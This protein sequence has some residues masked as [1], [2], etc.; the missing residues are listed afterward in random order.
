VGKMNTLLLGIAGSGKSRECIRRAADA[1]AAGKDI[2]YLVPNRDE[3]AL[4][5]RRLVEESG[6]RAALLPGIE[7]LTGLA[8]RLFGREEPGRSLRSPL[9]R[10]L[11]IS[12]QLAAHSGSLGVLE[13]S[14]TTPGFAQVLDSLFTELVEG[15]LLPSD[16]AAL[17]AERP[18]LLAG[19]YDEFLESQTTSLDSPQAMLRVVQA[20]E[21]DKSK[22]LPVSLLVADGFSN[23]SPLQLRFIDALMSGAE[24]ALFSICMDPADLDVSPRAP[25]E[26]LHRLAQHYNRKDNWQVQTFE[27]G[28]RYEVDGLASLATG[29]FREEKVEAISGL[30][31][32]SAATPRDEAEGVAGELRRALAAGLEASRAAILYR[33]ASYG[34]LFAEALA[35]AGVPFAFERKE[36]LARRPAATVL[37]ALLD[38]ASGLPV[39]D[40]P[41]RL[42]GGFV[43]SNDALFAELQAVGHARGLRSGQDWDT[44]FEEFQGKISK[45]DWAWLN[46]K[47]SLANKVHSG[48]TWLA[49]VL[50]PLLDIMVASVSKNSSPA[51]W[52]SFAEDLR[53]LE[54]LATCARQ[55]AAE[56]LDDSSKLPL[57]AWQTILRRGLEDSEYRVKA[58]GEGGGVILGNPFEM[59]LP[60]L[61]TVFICGLNRGSFPPPF[62]DHP[63]LRES[64]RLDL[65]D[66]LRAKGRSARLSTWDDRQAEE[67]YLFYV[68]ATRA[69]RRLVMT[70]SLRDMQGRQRPRSF[71][72]DEL[73][74]LAKLPKPRFLP[75]LSLETRLALPSS[76]RDLLRDSLLARGRK[77]SGTLQSSAEATLRDHGF[78][79]LLDSA[80]A[81]ANP[82]KLE[83]HAAL[84]NH[85]KGSKRF[86]PTA[87]E[88]YAQCPFRY[89]LQRLLGLEEDEN[90]TPGYLEEGKLE[91]KILELFY[92]EWTETLEGHALTARLDELLPQAAELLAEKDNLGSLLSHRFRAED[93]RRLRRLRL[94]IERDQLRMAATGFHPDP[95]SLEIGFEMDASELP[96]PGDG[97]SLRGYID[98]VD[99]DAEGRELVLDYKRSGKNSE[100]PD[101]DPPTLFQLPLYAMGR[102]TEVAGTAYFSV[103]DTKPFRGYF[104]Q[105]Q[106]AVQDDWAVKV[107][108]R[109]RF[110]AHFL[111]AQSWNDWL[112]SV[113]TRIHE[114]VELI[115]AGNL[116]PNPV[117]GEK[118]C[119]KCNFKRMCSWAPGV[120]GDGD[121]S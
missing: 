89:L 84:E 98:R 20:M 32:I 23:L 50:D 106:Q 86:S 113:S 65:N 95:D 101:T 62:R 99:R 80:S 25:F 74:R 107:S 110:G 12:R 103:K 53:E 108:T 40:L 70:Y 118:T 75:G 26:R 119:E 114:L 13:A 88:L 109:N 63:L 34:E 68:A 29:L 69:S 46:W 42:R 11:A 81:Q 96:V 105:D 22:A 85:L 104:H 79:E 47:Q 45:G 94:F 60:E 100:P 6:G 48:S 55:L 18:A 44:L 117:Q 115:R 35:R 97:F 2:L 72:L 54:A 41:Q 102:K 57:E 64:E 7:T 66:R 9:S 33:D 38:W 19:L 116:D 14:A 61:D 93:P 59:R 36:I 91:H 73:E 52:T 30:E 121:A 71:F 5:R 112:K 78:G 10:R 39:S 24:E 82:Q 27:P 56:A 31:L 83:G 4:V 67:R 111:D 17:G 21:S 76:P 87:F 15:E 92:R 90:S 28:G 3:A 49:E 37:L 8:R 120:N 58:G 43:G 51:T 1:V 77:T 16:L